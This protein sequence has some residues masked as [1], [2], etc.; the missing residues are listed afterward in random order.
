[1]SEAR[2]C[3]SGQGRRWCQPATQTERKSKKLDTSKC[4]SP[5]LV[6][7]YSF[8]SELRCL[9][10]AAAR[11]IYIHFRPTSCLA[12]LVNNSTTSVDTSLA[13]KRS[14]CTISVLRRKLAAPVVCACL[15]CCFMVAR[16]FH[17]FFR[18]RATKGFFKNSVVIKD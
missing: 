14:T 3:L 6:C 1:M 12:Q 8:P 4:S 15:W 16:T 7:G 5:H 18:K 10:S 17:H 2:R 11:L 9:A 13:K